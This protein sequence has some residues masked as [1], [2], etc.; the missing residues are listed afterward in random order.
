MKKENVRQMNYS[1][2]II[3]ER[4]SNTVVLKTTEC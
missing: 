1:E 3:K 4:E 2:Q